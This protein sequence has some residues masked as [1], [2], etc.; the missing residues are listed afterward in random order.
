MIDGRK[1]HTAHLELYLRSKV[2]VALIV[3]CADRCRVRRRRQI[4]ELSAY[5]SLRLL[6]GRSVP[7][8]SYLDLGSRI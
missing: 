4:L 8:R 3:D 2:Q 5:V 7:T 6:G 1:L